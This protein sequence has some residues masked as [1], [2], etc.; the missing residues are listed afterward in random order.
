M[1]RCG[2][3]YPGTYGHECGRPASLTG[4]CPSEFR[5]GQLFRAYRCAE[6]AQARTPDNAPFHA[7]TP[8]PETTE[9]A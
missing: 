4:T 7:W 2:H 8:I 3:A 5:P 1:K 9:A 6:C